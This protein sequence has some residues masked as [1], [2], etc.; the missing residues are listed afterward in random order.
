MEDF[1]DIRLKLL[2]RRQELAGRVSA[3]AQ[4]AGRGRPL[5]PDFEEQAVER[6][7]EEVLDAL[8]V[9]ARRELSQIA[10]AIDRMERGV[11]GVCASCGEAIPVERLR[12]VPYTD[13]CLSCAEERS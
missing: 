7:S 4:S 9:A 1:Q 10:R 12:A 8:E 3:I 5:D 2:D 11:Y 13:L 6:Q